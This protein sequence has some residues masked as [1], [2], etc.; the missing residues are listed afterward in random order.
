MHRAPATARPSRGLRCPPAPARR[1]PRPTDCLPEACSWSRA[2]T[3]PRGADRRRTATRRRGPAGP[4][5]RPDGAAG[6]RLRFP[7]RECRASPATSDAATRRPRH[8]AQGQPM[9]GPRAAKARSRPS[10]VLQAFAG[11]GVL[12]PL[13]QG[14]DG[15]VAGHRHRIG[16]GQVWEH[17][18]DQ[19]GVGEPVELAVDLVGRGA[20]VGS[21]GGRRRLHVGLG[22]RPAQALTRIEQL[23]RR[24]PA[25]GAAAR[26][27]VPHIEHGVIA[28]RQQL[29]LAG[30]AAAQHQDRAQDRG[31][32]NPNP[33]H[34][35]LRCVD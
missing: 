24:L 15:G 14:K 4:P 22:Q 17:V 25:T 31:R 20:R 27:L 32:F 10:V 2:G 35:C 5:R 9:R 23:P 13:I 29:V 19:I 21:S 28:V 12:H 33:T 6:H 16:A 7:A 30:G 1:S 8:A 18:H 11:H 26:L 34:A 3:P